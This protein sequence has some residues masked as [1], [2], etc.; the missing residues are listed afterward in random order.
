LTISLAFGDT[1]REDDVFKVED[2]EVVILEFVC[3]VYGDD[4][5]QS[6]NQ[7]ANAGNG[8]LRHWVIL[9]A[10]FPW[11]LTVWLSGG[12]RPQAEAYW[13]A[14]LASRPLEP[15]AIYTPLPVR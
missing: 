13:Q 14:P 9:P 4:L 2:R 3:G 15:L 7:I 8:Q 12:R 11:C 6:T 1:L 5:V 10:A